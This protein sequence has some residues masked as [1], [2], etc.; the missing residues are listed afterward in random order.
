MKNIGKRKVNIRFSGGTLIEIESVYYCRKGRHHK[1]NKKGFYPDFLLLGIYEQCTLNFISKIGMLATSCCSF[2]ESRKLSY[3]LLGY[4]IEV[5]KIYSIAKNLS[6][7]CE[8]A[9]DS[10]LL[11]F[12][13]SY[14]NLIVT[15]SVDGGRV[16]IRK[17]KKGK[18]TD[19]K[20]SRYHTDWREPKLMTIYAVDEN[21]KKDK[22]F[23]AIID[24]SI[25]GPD[26]VFT[27][28]IFYLRKL[29]VNNIKKLLFVSDGAKWIWNR[30]STIIYKLGL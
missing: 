17:N 26:T 30:V 4:N 21:G 10:G 13:E 8:L 28:L 27:L 14:S 12:E 9:R 5:N 29:G 15:V 19:K 1:V 16:R 2:E 18:K 3:M 20:R 22:N 24:G 11:E 25:S 6:K 7:R 23:K